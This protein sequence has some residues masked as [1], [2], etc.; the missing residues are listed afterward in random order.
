MLKIA[1]WLCFGMAATIALTTGIASEY[2]ALVT[3]LIQHAA[4]VLP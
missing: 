1:P 2:A 3:Q 4:E